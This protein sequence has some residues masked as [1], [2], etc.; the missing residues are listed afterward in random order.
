VKKTTAVR[1]ILG[2]NKNYFYQKIYILLNL[3]NFMAEIDDIVA[4]INMCIPVVSAIIQRGREGEEEILVQTRWK[5]EEDPEFSG[6][7]EIPAGW[8]DRYENVYDAVR[9]EVLEETGLKVTEIIGEKKQIISSEKRNITFA[10][11]PYRCYQQLKGG[12]PCIGLAFLCKVE[13][14]E[15]IVNEEECKEVRWI[16]KSELKEIIKNNPEKIFILHI[17]VL[18][19]Y[20]GINDPKEQNNDF[21]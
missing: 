8:V 1:N 12:V 4:K 10:L 15:P 6:L 13:D 18:S 20:C 19:H 2:T 17:G 16:K 7:L 9:R 14:K 21:N 11:Q 3:V 5:P